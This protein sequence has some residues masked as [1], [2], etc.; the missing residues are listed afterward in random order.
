MQSPQA[1]ESGYE[2]AADEWPYPEAPFLWIMEAKE[3]TVGSLIPSTMWDWRKDWPK[4]AAGVAIT[5]LLFAIL[6]VVTL[7]W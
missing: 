6:V 4:A 5:L 3:A 1:S 7:I 2:A